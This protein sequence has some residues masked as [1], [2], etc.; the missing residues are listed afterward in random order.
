[1]TQGSRMPIR[2]TP[3]GCR[4]S[5]PNHRN[6]TRS[7]LGAHRVSG[8]AATGQ[9]AK[10]QIPNYRHEETTM[11]NRRSFIGGMAAF[12]IGPVKGGRATAHGFAAEFESMWSRTQLY[13]LEFIEAMPG[14]DY[15]FKAAPE[16]RSYAEQLLHIAQGNFNWAGGIRGQPLDDIP[17]LTAEGKSRDEIRA[18]LDRSFNEVRNAVIGRTDAEL[19][20]QRV[21]WQR[22]LGAERSQSLKGVALTAWQH[23]A[24]HRGQLVVYLRLKGIV[25]PAY[26]D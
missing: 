13:T 23:A 9:S 15:G 25:P 3:A 6:S 11:L 12:G 5:R 10:G 18:I 1:M 26:S 4:R 20:Q 14:E 16:V 19:E 7:R 8:V 21:P 17:N 2:G 24:H 22:R